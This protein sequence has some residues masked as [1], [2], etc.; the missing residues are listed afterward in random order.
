MAH[1][2][3]LLAKS[4]IGTNNFLVHLA[5]FVIKRD[6]VLSPASIM[7]SRRRRRRQASSNV[8]QFGD[9]SVVENVT[10]VNQLKPSDY[11][12]KL[13]FSKM[14]ILL[15]FKISSFFQG[16]TSTYRVQYKR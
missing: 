3:L 16:Y 6:K 2:C 7:L 14:D 15:P 10:G 5:D 9:M 12:G 11:L 4:L 8:L 13:I 1:I